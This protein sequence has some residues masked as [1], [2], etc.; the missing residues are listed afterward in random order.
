MD[1]MNSWTTKKVLV[2]DDCDW[3]RE[4]IARVYEQQGMIVVGMC[5]NGLEAIKQCAIHKPDLVSLDIIMPEMDGLESYRE[6]AQ[7][8]PG[9]K[10]IFVSC[11]GANA[12]FLESL[13]EEIPSHLFLPKPLIAADL[14][15]C[16]T[17]IFS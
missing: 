5:E 13:K 2:V 1:T 16:L 10:F 14:Q 15:Q 7:T 6:L 11:L 4:E 9:L 12:K 3:I 17:K 8:N